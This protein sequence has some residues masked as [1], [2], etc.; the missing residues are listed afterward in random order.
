MCAVRLAS[1]HV[2]H[3][4]VHDCQRYHHRHHRVPAQSYR[5]APGK[6]LEKPDFVQTVGHRHQSRKP[7]EHVPGL[8]VS[9]YIV[10]F[11]DA[12]HHHQRQHQQRNSGGIDE[13]AAKDPEPQGE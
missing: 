11:N 6:P 13:V 12:S 7:H 9:Q 2:V 5:R 10:P 8:F 4:E 3:D 1:E